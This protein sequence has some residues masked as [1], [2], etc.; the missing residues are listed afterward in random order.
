MCIS[1]PKWPTCHRCVQIHGLYLFFLPQSHLGNV[2]V[3]VKLIDVKDTLP[4]GFIPIQETADTRESSSRST[5]PRE[6]FLP[7]GIFLDFPMCIFLWKYFRSPYHLPKNKPCNSCHVYNMV[8]QGACS[9]LVS[10]TRLSRMPFSLRTGLP[11][12]LVT[13]GWME[14]LAIVRP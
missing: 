12:G 1:K 10:A 2:L 4:V 7:P 11:T 9:V 5:H 6:G 13:R 3:D 14:K 8:P